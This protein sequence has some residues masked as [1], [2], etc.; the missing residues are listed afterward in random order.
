MRQSVQRKAPGVDV[1]DAPQLYTLAAACYQMF[2]EN[3]LS[4]PTMDLLKRWEKENGDFP[5]AVQMP[6]QGTWFRGRDRRCEVCS[7][8]FNSSGHEEGWKCPDLVIYRYRYEQ[9]QTL[10]EIALG[11]DRPTSYV[12]SR[13]LE[14]GA[15]LRSRGRRGREDSP[16]LM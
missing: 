8:P 13:L 5:P 6:D 4:S 10:A 14:S 7:W 9:G 16:D 15:E 12:R 3:P 1:I 11:V 2:S